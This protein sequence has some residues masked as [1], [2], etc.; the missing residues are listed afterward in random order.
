M[1]KLTKAERSDR[2]DR[3]KREAET[4]RHRRAAESVI[5]RAWMSSDAFLAWKLRGDR[6]ASRLWTYRYVRA[7]FHPNVWRAPPADYPGPLLQKLQDVKRRIAA[8]DYVFREDVV[9]LVLLLTQD[10]LVRFDQFAQWGLVD[11]DALD[12]LAD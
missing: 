11:V 8:G 3:Y 7:L 5:Y 4:A 9:D 2:I 10:E 6:D 12:A 1:K